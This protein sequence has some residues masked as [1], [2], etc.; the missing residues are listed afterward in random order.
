MQVQTN[1]FGILHSKYILVHELL[2]QIIATV[3]IGL[4]SFTENLSLLKVFDK[5]DVHTLKNVKNEVKFNRL[6]AMSNN[7]L[8]L[9]YIDS[10]SGPL[11]LDEI[12]DNKYYI[13]FQ[14][15]SKGSLIYYVKYLQKGFSEKICKY[16]FYKV[17]KGIEFLHKM[18][19]CHRNLSLE[20]ILLDGE[21][22]AI[23]LFDLSQAAYTYN[24]NGQKL[25]FNE[26][27][28][29]SN[30]T[31]PEII[32]GQYYD[33]EKS[34][35]FRLGVLLFQLRTGKEPKINKSQN[36]FESLYKLIIKNEIN[37]FWK[38]IE[39]NIGSIELSPEFKNLYIKLVSPYPKK[40]PTIEEIFNDEWLSEFKNLNEE[41]L[42]K[43][44]NEMINELKMREKKY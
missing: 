37:H 6:V 16:I 2:Y 25:L 31:A 15:A 7:P 3:F 34:D 23:K 39:Q 29:I 12:E 42:K 28:K 36:D 32:K 30:Y 41:G 1:Y 38:K 44:E 8:F 5:S 40:R 18:G 14:Y 33:G 17:L 27:G 11:R 24:E 4:D 21:N 19:I 9:Q 20:N 10:S 35:I 43:Y 13:K 26:K 22:Y